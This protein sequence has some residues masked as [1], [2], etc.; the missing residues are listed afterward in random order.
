MTQLR[1]RVMRRPVDRRFGF[2]GSSRQTC[3]G[4]RRVCS[5]AGCIALF[6]F[7][8]RGGWVL[9]FSARPRSRPPPPRSRLPRR[10]RPRSDTPRLPRDRRRRRGRGGASPS[11]PRA[12]RTPRVGDRVE[13]DE[14]GPAGAGRRLDG[15]DVAVPNQQRQAAAVV[16]VSVRQEDRVELGRVEAERHPV[17]DRF[18]R[19]ALEHPA[20]D[21]HLRPVGREQECRTGDGRRAAE[22]GDVHRLHGDR[23][24]GPAGVAPR[25][26]GVAP[27]LRT[28]GVGRGCAHLRS[29][30]ARR[31]R[32]PRQ[33]RQVAD[34]VL[35]EADRAWV[36]ASSEAPRR[37]RASACQMNTAPS[38]TAAPR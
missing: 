21:Q 22:E 7:F 10:G 23:P 29:G 12:W 36:D 14:G 5:W 11:A 32:W 35:V 26:A 24:H 6:F 28:R 37:H 38:P 25:G 16:E 30:R 4:Y 34:R 13:E 33:Q 1:F 3:S 15:A 18:V 19:A 9:A 17:A 27:P 2:D 31:W 20:I 8:H